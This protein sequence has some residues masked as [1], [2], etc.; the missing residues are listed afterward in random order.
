MKKVTV[1]L[2]EDTAKR[3]RFRAAERNMSLSR[4]VGEV[5]R[6]ELAATD[7]YEAAYRAWRKR[8]PFPLKGLPEPYP[9]RADLQRSR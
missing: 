6:R 8:K 4:Y 2:D 5:L 3:A 1:T 9:K 7:Q